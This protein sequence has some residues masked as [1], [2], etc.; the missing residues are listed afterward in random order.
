MTTETFDLLLPDG[1]TAHV[2]VERPELTED[3][4]Q[5]R[6]AIVRDGIARIIR[7]K[8]RE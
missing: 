7:E 4:K 2:T 8:Y 1:S 5:K 3:E 6:Y